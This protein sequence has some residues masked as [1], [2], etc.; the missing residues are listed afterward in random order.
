[1]ISVVQTSKSRPGTA[2]CATLGCLASAQLILGVVITALALADRLTV[3]GMIAV[4][5]DLIGSR[6]QL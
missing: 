3:V 6:G 5:S 4:P 2:D 1:M